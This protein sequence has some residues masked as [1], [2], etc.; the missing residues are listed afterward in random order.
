[1]SSLRY[2]IS[3][4]ALFLAPV[5]LVSA[6]LTASSSSG[7]GPLQTL[8]VNVGKFASDILI[9]FVIGI[10]FLV[11]VW[12]M[13]KFFILGGANDEEKEKGKSLMIYA[14]LGFVFILVFWG[15]VD[16]VIDTFGLSG[17]SNQV[18]VPKVP[19]Q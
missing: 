14:T 13:F 11:F 10:G 16:F 5:A 2:I 12:G 3:S 9:P 19:T 6:Q 18:K 1:M 17:E 8:V 4:V 7:A 15:I